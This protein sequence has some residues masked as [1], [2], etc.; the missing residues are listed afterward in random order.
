MVAA[1][2]S[3][4][5]ATL[6]SRTYTGVITP[7]ATTF[8]IVK[9][10]TGGNII[11]GSI[12][13]FSYKPTPVSE[14][15][16]NV[17]A[18]TGQD[19][20]QFNAGRGNV[21]VRS[22][23][24]PSRSMLSDRIEVYQPATY[25][26]YELGVWVMGGSVWLYTYER[27]RSDPSNTSLARVCVLKST[28]GL[29]GRAF[30]APVVQSFNSLIILHSVINADAG[31][32]N[33]RAIMGYSNPQ[34]LHRCEVSANGTFSTPV[35]LWTLANATEGYAVNA[36]NNGTVI[37]VF[38]V[39]TGGFLMQSV[40]TDWGLTFSAPVST[41]IGAATK[42]KPTPYLTLTP[43]FGNRVTTMF[44]DRGNGNRDLAS[45]LNPVSNVLSATWNATNFIGAP[46]TQGNGNGCVVS[47]NAREYLYVVAKENLP[48][49]DLYWWT[50]KDNFTT[51]NV[52]PNPWR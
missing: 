27:L 43:N 10:G 18:R 28:D 41:G 37:D 48:N 17:Y 5:K 47:V 6:D 15:T 38:R 22:F 1:I 16:I 40:S 20:D 3:A 8:T 35:R 46:A 50:M 30:S 24:I 44:N 49:T 11:A 45:A 29:V 25:A 52:P 34:G 31:G 13:E 7:S 42:A 26:V 36:D 12:Y 4:V 19:G 51:Y 2:H 9:G 23:D 32:V 33:K 14:T 21:S 39:D